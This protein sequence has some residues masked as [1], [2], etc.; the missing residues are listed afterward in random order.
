M[1]VTQRSR[2]LGPAEDVGN[3]SRRLLLDTN[4]II[5]FLS[6]LEPY[7][8]FLT[9]LFRRVL[10]AEAIMIISVVTESE[11]LVR[12]EREGNEQAIERIEDLLSEEGFTVVDVDRRIGRQAAKLRAAHGFKLPDAIIIATALE[13]RCD[14]VV[15]NDAA[16][17]RLPEFPFVHLDSQLVAT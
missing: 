2:A 12:P 8:S 11:L 10:R 3:S 16:W 4:A 13:T 7:L 9:P 1:S 6:G 5:Y 15:G 17:R 14:M